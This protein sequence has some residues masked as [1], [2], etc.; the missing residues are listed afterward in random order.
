MR[1]WLRDFLIDR[2]FCVRVGKSLSASYSTPSEVPQCSVLGP[3]LFVVYV[4]YLSGQLCS[5]S[6][7]YADDIKIWRTNG[8]PNV[9]SFL[10]ADLNNLAQSADT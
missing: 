4:N 10:Q 9:R 5:P 8:D 6:L 7:M 3:L 1:N 2:K